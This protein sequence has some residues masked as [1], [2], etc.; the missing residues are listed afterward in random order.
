MFVGLAVKY[1][2]LR[3]LHGPLSE[4]PGALVAHLE[5]VLVGHLLDLCEGLGGLGLQ[6]LHELYILDGAGFG[7]VGE[8]VSVNKRH[9]QFSDMLAVQQ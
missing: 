5:L 9:K 7:Y 1:S 2:L 3:E 4:A 6:P 8:W